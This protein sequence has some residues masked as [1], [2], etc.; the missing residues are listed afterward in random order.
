MC[1]EG[2]L[3]KFIEENEYVSNCVSNE[4]K[5][6]N[7]L[8][9]LIDKDKKLSQSDCI[10]MGHGIE[11]VFTDIILSKSGKKLTN[12]K[13][14]NTKGKKETDHLFLDEENKTIYYAELKSNLNLDTEKCKSTSE[15]CILIEKELNEIYDGYNVNMY[16]LGLRYYEK[17]LIPK[18]IS[19]KYE[20][21]HTNVIGVNEYFDLLNIDY[22]FK[23]EEEY[24]QFLNFMAFKL[25]DK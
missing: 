21:I 5:D 22:Q 19:K 17:S 18:T 24:K 6:F 14:K 8:S 16:L 2:S 10:K 12:I 3:F 11:N 7:S 25:F 23:D 15:K 13:R 1:E 20:N 4:K 9:Y